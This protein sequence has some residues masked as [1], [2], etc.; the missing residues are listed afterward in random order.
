M[1][2]IERISLKLICKVF[3][4]VEVDPIWCLNLSWMCW[5]LCDLVLWTLPGRQIIARKLDKA[6]NTVTKK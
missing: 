3:G 5:F 4:P 1:N 6:E 2:F